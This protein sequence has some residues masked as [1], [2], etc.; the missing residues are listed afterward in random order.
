[1]LLDQGHELAE[2]TAERPDTFFSL[3]EMVRERREGPFSIISPMMRKGISSQEGSAGWSRQGV[4]VAADAQLMA[5]DFVFLPD[6]E[7]MLI[8][9]AHGEAKETGVC[10][11]LHEDRKLFVEVRRN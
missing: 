11:S 8:R 2:V 1:V 6:V 10:G 7:R 3:M 5:S 9:E 4:A